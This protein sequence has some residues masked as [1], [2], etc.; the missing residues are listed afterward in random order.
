MH[1]FLVVCAS[2]AV[3]LQVAHAQGPQPR[4]APRAAATA[5]VPTKLPVRR[6]VLYKNGVGY[7]EHVGRVRGNQSLTIDFNT[8]QLNDV[9]KSLTTL[10]LGDG[11][12]ADVSFN[13]EAPFAQ[14]LGALT[15]P[16]GD[17]TTPL[18]LLG[19][20]RGA[21]LD[22]RSGERVI[23]GRL[24]S[25]ELRPRRDEAPRELLT[26]ITDAG[27]MRS[28]ELGP[29]VSVRIA[30]RDSAEQV[31]AYL[32]LLASNRSQDRR[33]M[34]I[35]AQGAGTRDVLVSYVSEVPVWKTNYRLVVPRGGGKPVLQGWRS[36]TTRSART[37]P[38]SSFRSS[39]A[40]R[41]RSSSRSRNR[42]IRG[43]RSSESRA[44]TC[45]G[46]KFIRRR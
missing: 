14:R 9:L 31:S 42:S 19:A 5:A 25:V 13:S 35:S 8:A 6:V 37:G 17:R 18:E 30:E 1:R 27:E 23:G 33:R 34:T 38:T 28:V 20:L 32:S 43:G 2:T 22:V 24:L 7:F 44:R 10:D 21:R 39:P 4:P 11:R 3:L 46:R 29:G 36:W 12:I 26:L 15:L 41:S 40:R 16:V 45:S